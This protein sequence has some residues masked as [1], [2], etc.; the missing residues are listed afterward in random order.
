MMKLRTIAATAALI[1]TALLA[2]AFAQ[3][4]VAGASITT[5]AKIAAIDKA[6]RTV[7]LVDSKG[8]KTDVQCGPEVKRFDELKVGQTVTFTYKEAVATKI[9]KADPNAPV[10]TDSQTMMRDKGPNPGGAVTRIQ[11]KIVTITAIDE[12]KPSV[13]VKLPDGSQAVLEVQDKNSL[14]GLKV[15]DH[16]SVTYAQ[17]FVVTVK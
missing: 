3:G 4:S 14:K 13:T 8:A 12:A 15:G 10:S 7:T 17:A 9:V 16:V 6:T 1:F 2:P 5:S 11:T